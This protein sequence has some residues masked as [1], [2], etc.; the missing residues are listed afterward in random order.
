[1]VVCLL[2]PPVLVPVISTFKYP[3]HLRYPDCQQVPAGPVPEHEIPAGTE[4]FVDH[5]FCGPSGNNKKIHVSRYLSCIEGSKCFFPPVAKCLFDLAAEISIKSLF[6][7]KTLPEIAHGIICRRG[8][9]SIY[10][11]PFF[12]ARRCIAGASR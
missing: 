8:G 6:F 3:G 1:M 7:T 12:P 9:S 11:H 10:N 5:I 2:F 4:I